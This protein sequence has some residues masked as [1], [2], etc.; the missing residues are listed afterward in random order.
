[1]KYKYLSILL[2]ALILLTACG[3]KTDPVAKSTLVDLTPPAAVFFNV[4]DDGVQITNNET[5]NLLIEKGIPDGDDCPFYNTVQLI[6]PKSV[7]VDKDVVIDQK[8]FYRVSKKT[9]AYGMLSAPYIAAVTYE[10]PLVI[11]S[12]SLL[13]TPSGYNVAID[14]D[15]IFMRFD[16]YS[17]GKSI[18]QTGTKTANIAA[19]DVTTD[20]LT[21]QLTDYYGNK[22]TAYKLDVPTQKKVILPSK[23]D[24]VSVL[25]LGTDRRIAWTDT[26]NADSYNVS[27]C[28]GSN[29]ENFTT[30]APSISY[31]KPINK[32]IDITVTAVNA[33]GQSQPTKVRYCKP[34]ED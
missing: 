29:C 13:K 5:Q 19:S 20:S 22:G 28:E 15:G 31:M 2:A 3:K 34:E 30:I 21:L 32:C 24:T 7:Y 12:A 11:N 26:E 6:G 9:V 14:T 33:D 10:K 8:Y 1:M 25:N 4:V 16:V 27:V 17:A 18:A 23:V